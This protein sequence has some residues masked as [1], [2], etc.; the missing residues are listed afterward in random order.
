MVHEI[1][2][3]HLNNTF[4]LGLIV[5]IKNKT[6]GLCRARDYTNECAT[7]VIKSAEFATSGR[8][9]DIVQGW[10]FSEEVL[11]MSKDKASQG[12]PVSYDHSEM[13][14]KCP[15]PAESKGKFTRKLSLVSHL[16]IVDVQNRFSCPWWTRVSFTDRFFHNSSSTSSESDDARQWRRT[17]IIFNSS[18]HRSLQFNPLLL[19]ERCSWDYFGL[20]SLHIILSRK[21]SQ[22]HQNWFDQSFGSDQ[23][24]ADGS[25]AERCSGQRTATSL[26]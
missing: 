5:I 21:P 24:H 11:T 16:R 15:A 25:V 7:F 2:Y 18:G 8:D 26:L 23:G 1:S 22:S 10:T 3:L 9:N 6:W 13:G 12:K 14:N 17:L 19:R 20:L 4:S